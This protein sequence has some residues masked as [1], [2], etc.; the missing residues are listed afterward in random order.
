VDSK[1]ILEQKRGESECC[2]A[3]SIFVTSEPLIAASWLFKKDK[4][5]KNCGGKK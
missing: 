5:E 4:E 3:H 2:L 1:K